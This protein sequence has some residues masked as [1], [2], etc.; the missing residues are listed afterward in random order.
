MVGT[1][2]EVS[3]FVAAWLL[4]HVFDRFELFHEAGHALAGVLL[5]YRV[6]EFSLNPSHS[7]VRLNKSPSKMPKMH[8]QM[9]GAMGGL[10]EAVVYFL[11]YWVF[12]NSFGFLPVWFS[13]SMVKVV[14]LAFLMDFPFFLFCAYAEGINDY[15]YVQLRDGKPKA[16]IISVLSIVIAYL[17]WWRFGYAYNYALYAAQVA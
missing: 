3:V 13:F 8:S 16:L 1:L 10:T 2:G 7:F 12:L 5:G 17:V 11:V 4:S 14:N 9:I 15:W 6:E